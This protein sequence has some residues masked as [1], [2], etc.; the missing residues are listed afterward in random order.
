LEVA[1][2]KQLSAEA[3]KALEEFDAAMGDADPRA[4]LKEAVSK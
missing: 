4:K 3:R 2:P 1:V